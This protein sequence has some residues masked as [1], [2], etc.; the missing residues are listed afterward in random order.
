MSIIA[1]FL[2]LF[3]VMEPIGNI[4]FFIAALKDIDRR[5]WPAIIFRE[6][7]IALA[8]LALFLF[9]G[10]HILAFFQI[11][12]PSLSIAG[13]II[14]FLIALNMIFKPQSD[15]FGKG[16]EGAPLIVPLA[17]PYIAGP[18]AIATLLLMTTR[19]PE[20]WR[21]WLIALAGAWSASL[22]ILLMT[23]PLSRLLGSKGLNAL[24]RLMGMFLTIIAVQMFTNGVLLIAQR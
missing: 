9:G 15:I 19:E 8:I 1:A 17:T 14:L 16:P 13:G 7:C 20:R 10:K 11:Q 23:D 3:L 12:E 24:E 22:I 6:H 5:R 18:S 2:L 4:P 21:E